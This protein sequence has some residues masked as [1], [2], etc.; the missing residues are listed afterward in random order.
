MPAEITPM[1][2]PTGPSAADWPMSGRFGRRLVAGLFFILAFRAPAASTSPAWSVHVW[3]SDDGLPNNNVTGLAQTPDGYLWIA[4][5]GQL[6]RFDGAN[7]EPFPSL[8]LAGLDYKVTS[9][10]CSRA[11]G[12]WLGMDHGGLVYLDGKKHPV[13]ITDGLP[14]LTASTLTEDDE[15]AIWILY[16]GSTVCR[17]KD[18][19]MTKFSKPNGLPVS[20]R[21]GGSLARDKQGHIW[22][23]TAGELDRFQ[24]GHFETVLQLGT[25]S[26]PLRLAA[27]RAGGFWI[28]AGLQLF[29][30]SIGEGKPVAVGT[31]QPDQ[32][33]TEPTVLL[34]DR[35]G[36]VWIGTSSSGLF[37]Y[38]ASG[39]VS[40]P[41]SHGAISSLVEDR[42]GHL[43]AGTVGGG[44]DRLPAA[45]DRDARC[46][47]R[48]AHA[49][50]AIHL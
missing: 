1:N 5:P 28:C 2:K 31:L 45:R 30:Y 26:T 47:N 14:N 23:A 49:G 25:P 48:A 7:F 46:A 13:F 39:V 15:G 19:Q 50:G 20:L 24:N 29:K 40:V 3:Q 11:G 6:A 10:L 38:D 18:G 4:N 41:T 21:A 35:H 32:P 9:L 37:R 44:L 22:L 36:A 33:N 42:E 12:L 17:F 43:W 16:G 8:D 27:A 34:E